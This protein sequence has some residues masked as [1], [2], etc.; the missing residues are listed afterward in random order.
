MRKY[1]LTLEVIRK[2]PLFKDLE[3]NILSRKKKKKKKKEKK[4][5]FPKGQRWEQFGLFKRQKEDQCG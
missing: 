5:A 3:Q 4:A 1:N 2:E